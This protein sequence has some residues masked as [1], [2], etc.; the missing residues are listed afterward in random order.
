MSISVKL[1]V[2]PDREESYRPIGRGGGADV[3]ETKKVGKA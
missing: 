3:R 1:D 2:N